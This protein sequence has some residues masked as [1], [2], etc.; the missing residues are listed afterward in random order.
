MKETDVRISYTSRDYI[1]SVAQRRCPPPIKVLQLSG[2]PDLKLVERIEQEAIVL[3][4]RNTLIRNDFYDA[5]VSKIPVVRITHALEHLVALKWLS[6]PSSRYSFVRG[7]Y[8]AVNIPANGMLGEDASL[9][10]MREELISYRAFTTALLQELQDRGGTWD[11][12]Q[13]DIL[14][15]TV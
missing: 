7:E 8:I 14:P 5:H 1:P 4:D 6:Q 11:Y 10:W 9:V 12:K 15:H 13:Q 3:T 2:N